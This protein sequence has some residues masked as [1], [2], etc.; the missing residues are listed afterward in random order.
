M[1]LL[2]V[3]NASLALKLVLPLNTG[4]P[5]TIPT[6]SDMV[7]VTVLSGVTVTVVVDVL[8]VMRSAN[9]NLPVAKKMGSPRVLYSLTIHASPSSSTTW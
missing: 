4:M 7:S 1:L 6:V 5:G 9:W 2:I 3:I 8:R